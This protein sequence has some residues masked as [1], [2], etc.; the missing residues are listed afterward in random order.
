MAVAVPAVVFICLMVFT[1]FLHARDLEDVF[2]LALEKDPRFAGMQYERNAEEEV[3]RQAWGEVLPTLTAEGA[4]TETSQEIISTDNE[5]Y[6]S[7]DSDYPTTEYTVSL[8]QPLFD[9]ASYMKIKSAGTNF[10]GAELE[11]AAAR[12]ELTVRVATAYFGVLAARDR[13]RVTGAEEAAV[14]SHYELVSEKFKRGLSPRTD[15]YEAKARL[16]EVRTK[17]LVAESDLDDARQALEEIIGDSA[18]SLAPLKEKL[19]LLSPEPGDAG[20]WIDAA[21]DQNPALKAIQQEVESAR[22]EIRRQRAGHYPSLDLEARYNRRDTEGTLFGGGSEVETVDVGVRLTVPIYQGGIVSSRTREA[23]H[24]KNALQQEKVRRTRA[25]EREARAAFFGVGNAIKRVK[26]LREAV[27]A[28]RLALEG[29]KDGYESGLFTILA[30]LDAERD[31]SLARLNYARARYEYI[32]NTLILKKTAG[33]LNDED[34]AGVN[35]WL[36]HS[37]D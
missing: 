22:Q 5:V 20:A 30:V 13:L 7:G 27:E 25:L 37:S 10:K 15:Y 23:G 11:V 35:G 14:K 28:Q 31:L 21:I 9:F 32:L 17:R 8:T 33:T 4:H 26:S 16:A 19:P 6:G 3:L 18:D 29:K 24:R 36:R 1:S 12:Q 34:I 2:E